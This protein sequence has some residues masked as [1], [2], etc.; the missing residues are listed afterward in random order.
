MT[1]AEL[2][3]N[4]AAACYDNSDVTGAN[5]IVNGEV[6]NVQYAI[7]RCNRLG[8]LVLAFPGTNQWTD[9][10]RHALVRRKYLHGLGG[11]VHRGWLA[12]WVD[13]RRAIFPR[14]MQD[15]REN[16][17]LLITGHS[18]GG[19]MGQ[20]AA[21]SFAKHIPSERILLYTYGSPRV[22]NRTFA[23]QLNALV[24]NHY[25]Y[26]VLNDPVPHLPFGI[27][28][29]HAGMHIKLGGKRNPHSIHTYKETIQ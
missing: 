22:G 1:F 10:W 3:V 4:T 24:M 28:Y 17:T 2:A 11:L 16:D 21:H 8:A 15:L 29:K 25:R 12:D 5:L 13:A 14:I 27:R 18:Y 7:Y 9:W 23:R 20:F 26:T 19:A 6:D